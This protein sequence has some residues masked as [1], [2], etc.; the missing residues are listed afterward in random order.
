MVLLVHVIEF[1][2]N[3][4]C[5]GVNNFFAHY[6]EAISINNAT[7][8]N[9]QTVAMPIT[10]FVK[11]SPRFGDEDGEVAGAKEITRAVLQYKI[12]PSGSWVTVK[13]IDNPDWSMNFDHPVVDYSEEIP[14]IFP[15]YRP[16]QKCSYACI[17]FG[18]NLRNRRSEY[19]HYQSSTEYRRRYPA[20][21]RMREDGARRT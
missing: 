6:T 19:G 10:V 9:G 7:Y 4:H 21:A 2:C 14:S 17:C 12:L 5:W 11:V 13:D 3:L 18:R 20:A 16:V 15:I 8:H 1:Q